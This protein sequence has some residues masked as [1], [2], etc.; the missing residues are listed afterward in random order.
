VT[1]GR[2]EKH[3]ST[4]R[5]YER[6]YNT[7]PSYNIKMDLAKGDREVVNLSVSITSEPLK[8]MHYVSMVRFSQHRSNRLRHAGGCVYHLP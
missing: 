2:E 3:D 1:G 7:T 6:E 4:S 8:C 5:A